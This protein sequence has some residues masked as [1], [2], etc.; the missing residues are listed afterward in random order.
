MTSR[1]TTRSHPQSPGAIWVALAAA[2]LIGI[3][4]GCAS[5][6][7]NGGPS[8]DPSTVQSVL[9]SYSDDLTFS[10]ADA[11]TQVIARTNR[12]EAHIYCTTLR[13]KTATWAMAAA[14][15]PNPYVGYADLL[16][17]ATLQRM[18]LEE[19]YARDALDNEEDRLLLYR[20][21][22]DVEERLWA[23]TEFA[24]TQFEKDELRA[25]IVAWRKKH[26]ERVNVI[27]LQ[28]QDFDRE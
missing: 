10:V 4:A 27:H 24:L 11:C 19:P 2:I 15:C 14:T 25:M 1:G 21:V 3:G 28:L 22:A 20:A 13:L 17:L 5:S 18:A 6:K 9:M 8:G 23:Q 16:T 7:K 26:P 12:P